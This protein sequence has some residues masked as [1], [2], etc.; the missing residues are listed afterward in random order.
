[1]NNHIAEAINTTQ[2]DINIS[3][4]NEHHASAWTLVCMHWYLLFPPI[5]WTNQIVHLDLSFISTIYKATWIT[6]HMHHHITHFK[7][8]LAHLEYTSHNKNKHQH[9]LLKKNIQKRFKFQNLDNECTFTKRK[10]A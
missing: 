2:K 9:T 1:M 6:I 4:P 10:Y 7:S 5:T 3:Q 8:L